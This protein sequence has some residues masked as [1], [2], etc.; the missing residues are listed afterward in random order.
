MGNL[1]RDNGIILLFLRKERKKLT[2]KL[3]CLESG[4]KPLKGTFFFQFRQVLEYRL[5][6]LIKGL[7]ET[8]DTN[9]KLE[10][11]G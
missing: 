3:I 5:N 10:V 2:G 8:L 7:L 4:E 9:L 11:Y 6:K 1:Q